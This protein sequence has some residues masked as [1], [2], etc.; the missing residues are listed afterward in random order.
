MLMTDQE[1]GA[2]DPE[3]NA[4]LRPSSKANSW[5]R[6]WDCMLDNPLLVRTATTLINAHARLVLGRRRAP[7]TFGY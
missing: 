5:L 6:H 7:R 4:V 3:S 1:I 2:M